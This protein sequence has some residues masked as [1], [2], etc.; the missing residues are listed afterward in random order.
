MRLKGLLIILAL[1]LLIGPAYARPI[2]F[3]FTDVDVVYV[4]LKLAEAE[5]KNIFISPEIHGSV[6]LAVHA[7]PPM[8]AMDMVLELQEDKFGYKILGDT[9]VVVPRE[10]LVRVR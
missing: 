7:K 5:E 9:I 2:S 10:K 4:L 3:D 6:T 8:E 1:G